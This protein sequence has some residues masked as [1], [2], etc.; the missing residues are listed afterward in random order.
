VRKVLSLKD[1]KNTL[2]WAPMSEHEPDVTG[3]TKCE[4]SAAR[5]RSLQHVFQPRQTGPSTVQNLR[6]TIHPCLDTVSVPYLVHHHRNMD[7]GVPIQMD[8]PN[9]LE[10]RVCTATLQRANCS[11]NLSTS[12]KRNLPSMTAQ[13]RTCQYISRLSIP[14]DRRY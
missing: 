14:Y 8:P 6:N 9:K 1:R 5:R 3:R 4:F 10:I 2:R 12:L 7:M 11:Q 13:T